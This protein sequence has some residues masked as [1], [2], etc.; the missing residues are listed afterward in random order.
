MS[1]YKIQ[2]TRQL[3]KAGIVNAP[4]LLCSTRIVDLQVPSSST[5][6]GG[7][8]L[9]FSFWNWASNMAVSLGLL[10]FCDARRLQRI[11]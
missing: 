1:A 4:I 5:N 8:Q 3:H 11:E 6:I 10:Q 9:N 2:P 7:H